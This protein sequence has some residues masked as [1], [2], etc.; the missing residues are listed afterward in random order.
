MGSGCLIGWLPE[1]RF[2]SLHDF[3][4]LILLMSFKVVGNKTD[5]HNRMKWSEFQSLAYQQAMGEILS[6]LWHAV[7]W[8][9]QIWC[10]DGILRWVYPFILG[11][12][13]DN[14]ERYVMPFMPL[15]LRSI[16][17]LS[18]TMLAMHGGNALKPCTIYHIPRDALHWLNMKHPQCSKLES[19]QIIQKAQTMGKGPVEDLLQSYG[20]HTHQVCVYK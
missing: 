10:A 20:L 14:Q 8:G 17:F 2:V 4:W 11:L 15:H 19:C 6:L 12:I 13:A 5:K 3:L 7:H 18:W 16:T 1:V 9:I